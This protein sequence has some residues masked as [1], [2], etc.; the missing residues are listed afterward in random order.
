M[1]FLHGWTLIPLALLSSC[2]AA[3]DAG[4]V[5]P[6][7]IAR[8]PPQASRAAPSQSCLSREARAALDVCA[9]PRARE[10]AARE[11]AVTTQA[12][13]ARL[14]RHELAASARACFRQS[15]ITEAVLTRK[16]GSKADA[17]AELRRQLDAYRAL[18]IP[19]GD[20]AARFACAND[21]ARMLVATAVAWHQEAFGSHGVPGTGDPKTIDLAAGLYELALT[22]FTR[23]DFARFEFLRIAR[24]DWP[25]PFKIRYWLADLLYATKDWTRCGPAFTA[26]ASEDPDDPKAAEAAYASVLCYQNVYTARHEAG[27][28]KDDPKQSTPRDLTE[29]EQA[30]V[31]AFGRYL[32]TVKPPA[33]DT[34]ASD[35]YV[36]IKYARARL[37]FEA[38]RWE[39]AAIA[40]RDVAMSH[41]DKEVGIYAAQLY[42]EALNQLGGSVQ[43][44][45]PACYEDMGRDVP[46]FV[47]LYCKGDA[48]KSN[49]EACSTLDRIQDDLHRLHAGAR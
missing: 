18:A 43:P 24:A 22:S 12:A 23:E 26:A 25:T 4:T 3:G 19:A 28:E 7:S 27:A 1:R 8:R 44:S 39:E 40:F 11:P 41:A 13:P 36:E 35:T 14:D 17:M 42:L 21:T 49:A 31:A 48:R 9:D 10:Q 20:R 32:C 47:E 6:T 38:R 15:R 30:M 46:R 5:S 2:G 37:Y 34:A 29:A 45:R 33:G 16:A